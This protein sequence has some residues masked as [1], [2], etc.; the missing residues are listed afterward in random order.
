VV[1]RTLAEAPHIG[2]LTVMTQ[3]EVG[4]RLAAPPGSRL[5]GQPSV[6]AA[7][8]AHARVSAQVSRRA[9]WPVP[10]IDSTIVK[11]TRR[12]PPSVAAE[13]FSLVVKAAFSQRRKT[14]RN[15][16]APAAGG[17]KAATQILKRAGIGPSSRAE[18]LTRE[19]FAAI[20]SE[21]HVSQ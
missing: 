4:E 7:Y 11:I 20:A 9:F 18:Q 8:Y 19:D 6:M 14:L 12:K 1:L 16:L 17:T 3:K 21:W 13:T 5:Y 2:E 10:N 15:A